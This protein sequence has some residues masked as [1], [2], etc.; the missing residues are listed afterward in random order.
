LEKPAKRAL[1]RWGK[2]GFFDELLGGSKKESY[3][4]GDRRILIRGG[5]ETGSFQVG[6]AYDVRNSRT[7]LTG[8]VSFGTLNVGNKLKL[9]E[10]VAEIM[11]IEI[12]RKSKEQANK[13]ES[14][15]ITLSNVAKGDFKEGDLLSFKTK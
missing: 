2:M 8:K 4:P 1:L 5:I 13:G 7:V 12:N 14:A 6:E 3:V 10:K 15:I 9:G 11:A